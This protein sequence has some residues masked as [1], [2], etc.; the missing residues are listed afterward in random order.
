MTHLRVDELLFVNFDIGPLLLRKIDVKGLAK[1][2]V[3]VTK[4]QQYRF[5][6]TTG[7]SNLDETPMLTVIMG[8]IDATG[9]M[10]V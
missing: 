5:G 4:W 1:V 8:P 7:I 9:I 2:S 6:H 3:K 10:V